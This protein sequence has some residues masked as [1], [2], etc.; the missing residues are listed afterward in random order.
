MD[1]DMGCVGLEGNDNEHNKRYVEVNDD[2]ENQ[3]MRNLGEVWTEI[4]M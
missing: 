3:T 4:I 1:E 2:V